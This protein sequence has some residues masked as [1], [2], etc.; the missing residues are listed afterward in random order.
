MADPKSICNLGLAKI[1]ANRVNSLNPPKSPIERH[2]AEGYAQWRDSELTKRRWVFATRVEAL[3][4]VGPDLT[5][6][7]DG[8]KYKFALPNDC[9]RPLR[10]KHT[11]W[12][13]R[14]NFLYSDSEEPIELE[15]IFRCPEANMTSL[16]IDVLAARVAVESVEYATQSNTKAEAVER[17]YANSVSIAGRSNA[18]IIGPEDVTLA[19]ENSEWIT[20]RFDF[21][22]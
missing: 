3:S 18:F 9:L 1:A 14:G 5:N 19:D 13:Q 12:V 10:D 15:F 6:P 7:S 16:F 8:R 20:A 2:C 22:G 21:P 17:M 4:K 11:R